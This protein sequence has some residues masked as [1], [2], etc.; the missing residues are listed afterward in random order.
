[1]DT[2]DSDN[3]L[4]DTQAHQVTEDR[5][6]WIITAVVLT[7]ILAIGFAGF[8]VL[9]RESFKEKL[10]ADVIIGLNATSLALILACA[11]FFAFRYFED[12]FYLFIAIG[13][14]AN[15]SYLPFE[16]LFVSK[17]NASFGYDP[18][19]CYSFAL[20][21]Y[22]LSF[23]SSLAF[24]LATLTKRK[25]DSRFTVSNTLVMWALYIFVFT[26]GSYATFTYFSPANSEGSYALRFMVYSTPG[27]IF[28]FYGLFRVAQHISGVL[29]VPQTTSNRTLRTL[30]VTFYIYAALQLAY[31]FKI[32]LFE[33]KATLV[34]L[35]FF[36]IAF[37]MKVTNVYCLVKVLLQVKYPEFVRAKDAVEELQERLSRQSQLAALGAIAA[38]IE[39]D[40]KT[41]LSGISTSLAAMRNRYAD[42][43]IVWYIDQLESDKNRIA[44]IA[45]V[46]PFMRGAEDFY[47]RDRFMGKVPVSEVIHLAI[48]VVKAEM[49][50]DTERYF[51]RLNPGPDGKPQEKFIECFVRAYTPMLEQMIVNLFKNA[52]EAIRETGRDKGVIIIRINT[53][54]SSAKEIVALNPKMKYSRWVRIDIE[55]NGCGIPEENLPKLTTLF[56]TKNDRKPN[57]GIGLYIAHRLLKVHEGRMQIISKESEGTIVT[58]YLPE[59]DAYQEYALKH[60]EDKGSE[61]MRDEIQDLD[62]F[63]EEKTVVANNIG[64]GGVVDPIASNQET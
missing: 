16:F 24:Y 58:I 49:S 8:V 43:K 42:K 60:P 2:S 55:D 32:I 39:H 18:F 3:P 19:H 26:A 23:V 22:A 31:P 17:C 54:R 44:A 61:D 29:N 34:F 4:H 41:P 14:L 10:D 40:M 51:F 11:Y 48:R 38:S 50:L 15:A 56:T 33:A 52:I 47:N 20:Y 9:Y 35:S 57:G 30:S 5:R 63:P 25:S 27:V 45:K 13:W 53:V 21:T 6:Q 36:L 12:L 64:K 62:L 46:V 1:M 59:W 37:A 7:I 28:A